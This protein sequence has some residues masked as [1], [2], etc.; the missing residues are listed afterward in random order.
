MYFKTF[1]MPCLHI[2]FFTSAPILELTAVENFAKWWKGIP[3][4]P[5][6]LVRFQKSIDQICG[7]KGAY[8]IKRGVQRRVERTVFWSRAFLISLFFAAAPR[9]HFGISCLYGYG[10]SYCVKKFLW[11]KLALTDVVLWVYTVHTRLF[12]ERSRNF[13]TLIVRLNIE[14][15]AETTSIFRWSPAW[16]RETVARSSA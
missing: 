15:K 1:W 6:S 8:E 11:D 10:I 16:V 13:F 9:N 12:V 7:E 4:N 3:W 14:A 2:N 5:G